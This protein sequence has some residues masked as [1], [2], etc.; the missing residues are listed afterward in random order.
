MKVQ[1]S[2]HILGGLLALLFL[3]TVA[4][5]QNDYNAE[6]QKW[7]AQREEKLKADDGWLTVAGLFWLKDGVNTIGTSPASDIIL[8]PKSA[9][10]KV[11][12]F[13]YRNGK[14][15]FRA[16]EGVSVTA[17]DKFA[18]EFDVKTDADGKPDVIK[19][20]DLSFTVLKRGDRFG[21]RLKDKNARTRQE[22]A[23][24]NWYA[25]AES[26]RVTAKFIAYDQ[27]KE[28]SI[29]NIIGD[30]EKMK[31]PGYVVFTLNGQE[32]TLEPVSS[33]KDKLFFIFR[34]LTSGKTTY[35]P[36]R[37]LYADAPK[38]G[39]VVL[40]FNQAINPPCAF[41]AFATCPLPIKRNHLPIAIEAGE[42]LYNDPTRSHD[43]ASS[44]NE[45]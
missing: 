43:V 35:K 44:A 9:P 19:I 14:T 20:A 39:T 24:L 18:C 15:I 23:G 45:H 13:E 10:A 2:S 33:G 26:N 3:A 42:K 38:D 31:S 29:V 28:V 16:A 37:F 1:G 21:I 41:T 22:F 27:P 17:N 40:D 5:A 4:V 11:G 6:T 8:P 7:R 36:G 32:L 25:P 34:D 12:E 30:I